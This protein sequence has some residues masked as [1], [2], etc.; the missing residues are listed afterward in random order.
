MKTV[1]LLRTQRYVY[2]DQ[3]FVLGKNYTV[4]DDLA[5]KLLEDEDSHGL[6]Y[7]VETSTDTKKMERETTIRRA[8]KTPARRKE[9]VENV[10]TI[11]ADEGVEV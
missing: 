10:G 4:K 6:P 1:K 7:F 11:E 3:L 8:S 2:G 5:E 9:V